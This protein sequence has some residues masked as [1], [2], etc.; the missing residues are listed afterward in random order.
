MSLTIEPSVAVETASVTPR[1]SNR[2][3]AAIAPADFDLIEPHLELIPLR[4]GQVLVEPGEDV[5]VTYFPA[6]RTM[7]SV[8]IVTSDGHEVEAATI[9]R[10][11]ALGGIVSAGAKPA[12]GRAAVQIPGSA[13][14]VPTVT[15]EEAK[16]ASPAL[17]ELFARYADALL[18]QM[19]QSIACNALHSVEE[20]C[21]RWLLAAH[22][23]AGKQ[24]LQLTQEALAEMLGVQRTTVT[25]VLQG[26]EA[27]GV[28]RGRRGSV[29]IADRAGLERLACECHQAVEDHFATM[30]PEVKL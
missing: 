23:R 16:A 25:A 22:D 21:C 27:K 7:V 29:E 13:F 30:L 14:A 11:G 26:L 8:L 20:R 17:R 19:M 3:L 2:L 10:E 5:M 6:E 4:R 9:G 28:V 12:Y 15:L 1:A 18:A 24:V